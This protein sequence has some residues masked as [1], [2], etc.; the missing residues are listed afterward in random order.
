M[1]G[2][3]SLNPVAIQQFFD[4]NGDP[5]SGGKLFFYLAGTNTPSPVYNDQLLVTPLANPLVLDAAGRAPLHYLDALSYKEVLKNALDVTIWTADNVTSPA[6]LRNAQGTFAASGIQHS[7]PVPP[8]LIST[9]TLT[10]TALLSIDGFSGATPGQLLIVRAQGAGQVNLLHRQG[11]APG[12]QLSNYVTSGPTPLS[13]LGGSA[14]YIYQPPYWVLL[15]HEQGAMI[16][17]PYNAANFQATPV[18]GVSWAVQ[19]ED[20]GAMEYRLQGNA[21]LIT[22]ALYF[23]SVTGAPAFLETSGWP[24]VFRSGTGQLPATCFDN[25]GWEPALGGTYQGSSVVRFRRAAES[26]NWSPSTNGTH[27]F[28]Q[29]TLD[30]Y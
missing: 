9:L 22:V 23:T 30:V 25:T 29:L 28:T 13:G 21:I 10:N 3:G 7:V 18:G 1:A 20:V 6:A 15:S 26:V 8:G 19:A 14:M 2:L 11:S 5:L 4:S 27:V 24:Y 17:L 16:A 12:D